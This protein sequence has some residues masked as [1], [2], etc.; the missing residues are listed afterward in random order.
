MAPVLRTLLLALLCVLAAVA[1]G[2]TLAHAGERRVCA[3]RRHRVEAREPFAGVLR[4]GEEAGVDEVLAPDEVPAQQGEEAPAAKPK[5]KPEP[6]PPAAGAKPKPAKPKPGAGTKAGQCTVWGP[7]LQTTAAG[8]AGDGSWQ[9]SR[10]GRYQYDQNNGY[11]GEV[12]LQVLMLEHGVWIPQEAARAAGGGE[13]LPGLNYDRALQKLKV[14]YEAFK[15]R[16]YD[17]FM[18]WTKAQLQKGLGVVTVGYFRGG[19]D[20]EYDHIMPVVAYKACPSGDA[21]LVHS[22]YDTRPVERALA[23]FSCTKNNK[24][25]A[26]KRAGCVPRDTRWGYAIKGAAGAPAGPR[27]ELFVQNPREPGLGKSV[28]MA[29]RVR[30]SGLQ[31]GRRYALHRLGA[32]PKTAAEAAAASQW[33]QAFVADAA[34]RVVDVAFASNKVAHFVCVAA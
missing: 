25:D 1:G 15:G 12:S 3:A 8:K 23:D 32:Q 2:H 27:A 34:D 7:A 11:C 17:E 4:E 19:R 33:S 21:V 5:P 14:A 9:Q 20:S 22:N 18:R 10:R 26:I 24:K 13:L 28:Q 29:G 6:K 30:L 16:G 31:P